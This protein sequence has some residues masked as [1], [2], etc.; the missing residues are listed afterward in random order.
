MSDEYQ[1]MCRPDDAFKP[2]R[3]SMVTTRS[4]P[5]LVLRRTAAAT[6]MASGTCQVSQSC[7][8]TPV[9]FAAAMTCG[10]YHGRLDRTEPLAGPRCTTYS[11][12]PTAPTIP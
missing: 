10:P 2:A 12:R 11:A 7:A 1:T 5:I 4:V 3:H 8:Y 9:T 6:D